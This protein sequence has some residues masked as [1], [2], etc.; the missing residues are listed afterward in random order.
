[1]LTETIA[2]GRGSRPNSD[3]C[4]GPPA[5]RVER[6]PVHGCEDGVLADFASVDLD[7][8]P[9]PCACRKAIGVDGPKEVIPN[10]VAVLG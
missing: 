6:I 1:M 8:P 4:L 3:V 10:S 9:C 7:R 2:S 5:V